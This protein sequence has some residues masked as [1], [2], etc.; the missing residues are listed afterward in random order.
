VEYSVSWISILNQIFV[1]F[2][3]LNSLACCINQVYSG[4]D[5]FRFSK[6]V[7]TITLNG[8]KCKFKIL[9]IVQTNAVLFLKSLSERVGSDI[10][11][12]Y[13]DSEIDF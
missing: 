3:K 8:E 11:D 7:I 10:Q 4:F 6:N 9:R 2:N 5:I 12:M 1:D 13:N